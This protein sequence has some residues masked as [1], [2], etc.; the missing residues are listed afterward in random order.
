MRASD[1]GVEL[2]VAI[3]GAGPVG[4]ALAAALARE[5][6]AVALA[7]RNPVTMSDRDAGDDDWDARVYAISPGSAEFLRSLGAWQRLPG[8][9][10]CA[11]E[12]MDIRRDTSG[13]IEFSAYE[14]GERSLAWIVEH[15]ELVRALVAAVRTAER[16]DVLAPCEP[17]AISWH[18]DAAELSLA[19]G[20]ALCARLVVG[21]DG[22]RSWEREEGRGKRRTRRSPH[23]DV[24]HHI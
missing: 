12:T 15:R 22:L 20:R 24:V 5:N 23:T 19:D 11:I 17:S 14:L 8:E 2:D 1:P 9:R 21:A 3:L 6:L 4:L 16:I 10:I 18:A 7:D 13:R